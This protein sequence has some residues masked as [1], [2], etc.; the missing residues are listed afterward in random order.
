MEPAR[1]GG[2]VSPDVYYKTELVYR[3]NPSELKQDSMHPK[4]DE[5]TP[6]RQT[7]NGPCTTEKLEIVTG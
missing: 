4:S 5:W 1:L 6:I 3:V 7:R 2:H